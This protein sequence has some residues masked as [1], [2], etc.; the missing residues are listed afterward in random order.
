M[1]QV[2]RAVDQAVVHEQRKRQARDEALQQQVWLRNVSAGLAILVGIP[3]LFILFIARNREV[4]RRIETELELKKLTGDLE[5]RV[6]LGTAELQQSMG[7]ID[8]VLKHI[9]DPVFLI[10]TENNTAILIWS[11]VDSP[12]GSI[13]NRKRYEE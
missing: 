11:P 7:F 12:G 2:R 4:A 13:D 5:N 9:P 10:D 6:A 3:L 1:D 8:L